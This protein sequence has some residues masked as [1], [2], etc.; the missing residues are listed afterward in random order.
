M[1]LRN[2]RRAVPAVDDLM[3]GLGIHM[4]QRRKLPGRCLDGVDDEL[5][6]LLH[7]ECWSRLDLDLDI[8]RLFVL[9]LP[10]RGLLVLG[11]LV[12]GLL[13]LPCM[14]CFRAPS[15]P[16]DEPEDENDDDDES[17]SESEP[18]LSLLALATAFLAW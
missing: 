1:T 5:G 7:A 10:V 18:E 2:P 12:L 15:P 9:R 16:A 8:L 6:Q 3:Q 14:M 11:L 4:V 17:D 13:V